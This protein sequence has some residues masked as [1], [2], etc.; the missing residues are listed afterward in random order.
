MRR[1]GRHSDCATRALACASI[2]APSVHH[3]KARMKA[4]LSA[5][6]RSSRDRR[7]SPPPSRN[8]RTAACNNPTSHQAYSPAE[9]PVRRA[10]REREPEQCAE[11]RIIA[12]FERR[13][14]RGARNPSFARSRGL[15]AD[16]VGSQAARGV[17]LA[18]LER[19][20]NGQYM[21]V[22]AARAEREPQQ[23]AMHRISE[24]PRQDIC[25]HECGGDRRN[26]QNTPCRDACDAAE[27]RPFS[28]GI[29]YTLDGFSAAPKSN[30]R[31]S[32]ARL[33]K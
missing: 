18:R 26:N 19:A 27:R 33:S 22:E 30:Q 10:A 6:E 15:S 14:D 23:D 12:V 21:S 16:S 4:R 17:E 11:N 31:M 20:L 24:W 32:A 9:T 2:A 29:E 25:E 8:G 1:P 7:F 3:R 13:L 28:L 5:R